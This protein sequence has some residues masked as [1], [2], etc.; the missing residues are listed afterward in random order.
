MLKKNFQSYLTH[1]LARGLD[2]DSPDSMI[3]RS[4]IIREKPLLRHFYQDC[5]QFIMNGIPVN[6]GGIVLEIG[7]G[8]GFLK[9]FL[10]DV[11]TSEIL[12][13]PSVDIV[14]DARTLPLRRNCLRAIVMVDVFH[15]LSNVK[16]FLAE[17]MTC[18]RP[19]G[20]L[21]MVEP[22]IT[23]WSDFVYRFFHHEPI[24][25]NSIEWSF[26]G[27]GPLS[28]ANT[29]LAWIVFQRDR[30]KFHA[31]F[32]EWNIEQIKLDYPFCY[33]VSGGL[34]FRSLMPARAF[35]FIRRLENL[36][37]PV[38]GSVAMF[39]KITLRRKKKNC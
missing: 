9:D 14:L 39:A 8:A 17:A 25:K 3:H 7:S 16:S 11:V 5:Y 33:L 15:H 4:R 18:V 38:M 31:E 23:A 34:S 21:L 35:G 19:G 10:P 29:A 2:I 28:S 20:T 32:P 12:T 36:L 24:D 26:S 37:Q 6:G 1:P 22:W 30:Q 27:N 13:I